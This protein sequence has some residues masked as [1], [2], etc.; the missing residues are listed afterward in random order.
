MSRHTKE[1]LARLR[2]EPCW[3]PQLP[4]PP[5]YGPI[6]PRTL[7]GTDHLEVWPF[8]ELGESHLAE[9][10]EQ[11]SWP[12]PPARWMYF[13]AP[14]DPHP[15]AAMETR[16]WHEWYWQR[17]R[18]PDRREAIPKWMRLA[19]IE[20]DGMVCGLCLDVIEDPAAIHIDHIVPVSLGGDTVM[21]NLQVAHAFCN[22]SKGNRV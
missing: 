1:R 12:V 5:V 10:Y 17:G 8:E 7:K 13:G 14:G 21:G 22:M 2:G 9:L 15:L 18:R 3:Q 20:R 4:P 6:Y 16:G 11:I 19:V